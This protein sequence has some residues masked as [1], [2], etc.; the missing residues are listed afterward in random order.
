MIG[1]PTALLLP[2]GAGPEQLAALR[3]ALGLERPLALQYGHYLLAALHGDFGTSFVHGRPALALVLERL[4]ATATLAAAALGLGVALGLAAGL[5]GALARPRWLRATAM[6]LAALGQATPAFW[7][8]IVLVMG[9]SVRLGWLPTGGNG[10]PA[11]LL[12]PALTLA[13]AI[14]ASVA[15]LLR[16]SVLE[17]LTEDHVRTARAKGL[18][19]ATILCWHVLRNALAP[20]LTLTGILAG[21]LLGGAIVVETVFAWPGIGRLLIQAIGGR[22]F[23]VVQA[24]VLVIA[25]AYVGINLLVDLGYGLLDPRLRRS[26]R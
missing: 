11:H 1:D 25:L 20:V 13:A 15:R 6:A 18:L 4:P 14:A 7:L 21:E 12:L 19:P 5:I 2:V 22:D 10:G 24:A 9:F 16:A 26:G 8:G 17:V 23:P 3:A